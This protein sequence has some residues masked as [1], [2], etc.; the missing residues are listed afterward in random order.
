MTHATKKNFILLLTLS[1]VILISACSSAPAQLSIVKSHS[2]AF[3]AGINGTYNIAV[4]NNSRA[5]NGTT[6][7]TDVLPTGMTFVSGTGTG[8]L[9]SANGQ[10]VTCANSSSLAPNSSTSIALVVAVASNVTGSVSNTATVTN[11]GDF[12]TGPSDSSTD[13]MTVNSSSAPHLSIT[14]SHSGNFTAGTNG[15]FTVAVSNSGSVATTGAITVTDTLPAGLTFVSG[16]GTNWTCA[17]A[18]QVVTCTNPGPIASSASAGNITLTTAV[19]SAAPASISNTATAATTGSA[20]ASSTDTVTVTSAAAPDLSIAKS[21]SGNFTA[22]TNGVFMIAVSNVGSAPTTG[23]ITVTDTLNASFGFVSASGTNWTCAAVSQLVT[24]TNPG[25]IANGASA[26]NIALT[27][28]VAGSTSAGNLTNTAIVATAGDTNAGNNSSTDTVA[29]TAAPDLAITDSATSAFTPGA[30]GTFG[31]TVNNASTGPTLGAITVS[32]T[33]NSNFTFVSGAGTGWTCSAAA[34]VVTCTN[35]GPIAGGA[36]AGTITLTVGVNAAA[37]GNISNTATVATTDDNNAANNSSTISVPIGVNPPD[38]SITKTAVGV[39]SASSSASYTIAVSNV[40]AG[41]TTGAITVTD[42]LNSAFTFI[43]G[44][45]TNWTCANVAQVVTCTNPGPIAASASAGNINLIV[46]VGNS[47]SGSISNTAT[48]ATTGDSNA[49]NNSSTATVTIGGA[50]GPDLAITKSVTGSIPAG[51]TGTFAI[52]VKNNGTGSTTGAI[53]VTDTLNSAFTFVMA[54]GANWT[55]TPA[56]QVV[57]CTNPGPIAASASAGD[58]ILQVAV[59]ATASGSISNT[60]TVSDPGDTTDT[61]DKSSTV[62]AT[63][64][65][66]PPTSTNLVETGTTPISNST[67]QLYA[68]GTSADGSASDPLFTGTVTTNATGNFTLPTFTCPTPGSL[69][70]IT[71]TGGNPGLAAGTDNTAIT[72]MSALGACSSVTSATPIVINELTSVA[73]VFALETYMTSPTAIGSSAADAA[74]LANDFASVNELV[75]VTKGTTPGPALPANESVTVATLNTLA[76]I[77][78]ACDATVGGVAGDSSPCGNLF[79][80]AT[81]PT[82]AASASPESNSVTPLTAVPAVGGI[83]LGSRLIAGR[84]APQVTAAVAPTTTASAAQSMAAN[85]QNNVPALSALASTNAPF[86]PQ[87]SSVPAAWDVIIIPGIGSTTN[88]FVTSSLPSGVF[89]AVGTTGSFGTSVINVTAVP[90]TLTV[91]PT[92]LT[93][94]PV[95]LLACQTGSNTNQCLAPPSASFSVTIPPNGGT[96]SFETFV[97]FTGAIPYNPVNNF[98][99]LTFSDSHGTVQAVGFANVNSVQNIDSFEVLAA[100]GSGNGVVAVPFSTQGVGAFA[101]VAANFGAPITG[102]F[103]QTT[104]GALPVDVTVCQTD[105]ASGQCLAPP[106]QAGVGNAGL[107][108]S[109]TKGSSATYSIFIVASAAIPSDPINN[110][111]YVQFTDGSGN[112][113]AFTSVAVVTN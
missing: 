13:T 26:G 68:V 101:V 32:D 97:T 51:T 106:T 1:L 85:P 59:S 86:E 11:S 31:I 39:F 94:L 29:V 69:V 58:I 28:L 34:Q 36:A 84:P 48:V 50:I 21:H 60:A 44:S 108:V 79:T 89:G 4:S 25:P 100:T 20:S 47:A 56:A 9:C 42:T 70:Y 61:A 74:D 5:T 103:L 3:T 57:T 14:K 43:S 112:L 30:N 73:S 35:P 110:R 75:D 66:A 107:P 65:G 40:G 27:V 88:N 98:V 83:R 113:L 109:L 105:P 49:A 78:A 18:T 80:A 77:L 72:L 62:S 82:A 64:T 54:T 12:I 52:A 6:T 91:T 2:T 7:V 104:Q 63:I 55:C 17:A 33:L 71:A 90:Q 10:T 96:A 67:I 16:T 8:W 111:I 92:T 53:T 93:S 37:T 87:Q 46:A 102:A 22:G 38:L 15:V 45:G 81:P 41:P 95:T 19:A 24:C 76:D 99:F 23:A